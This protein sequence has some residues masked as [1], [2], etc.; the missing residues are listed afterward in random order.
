[1]LSKFILIETK[2]IAW[3]ACKNP[4]NGSSHVKGPPP[5]VANELRLQLARYD[6]LCD[7]VETRL[8]RNL[9]LQANNIILF[10]SAPR[11]AHML[12]SP[13]AWS[14]NVQPILR[15]R[16]KISLYKST[17]QCLTMSRSRYLIQLL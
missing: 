3:A 14:A 6:Q 12:P 2:V 8:V 16:I 4:R 5:A 10:G 15:S 13:L 1:M 11:F 17:R 7:I 9:P